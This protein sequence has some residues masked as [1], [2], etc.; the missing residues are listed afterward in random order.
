MKKCPKNLQIGSFSDIRHKKVY[1]LWYKN[2]FKNLAIESY[3]QY[4]VN[5]VEPKLFIFGSGTTF[6]PTATAL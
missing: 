6:A 4:I 5:S 2:I 1:K 3:V